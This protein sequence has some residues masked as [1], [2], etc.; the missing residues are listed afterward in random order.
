[1]YKVINSGSAKVVKAFIKPLYFNSHS[2][3]SATK[4]SFSNLNQKYTLKYT[5]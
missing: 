2:S 3:C 1:M 5:V 4:T